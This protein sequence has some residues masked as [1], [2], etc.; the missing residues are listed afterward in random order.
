M[1]N[2]QQTTRRS[3]TTTFEVNSKRIADLEFGIAVAERNGDAITEALMNHPA[4]ATWNGLQALGIDH[5]LAAELLQRMEMPR[6]S[7]VYFDYLIPILPPEKRNHPAFVRIQEKLGFTP[8]WRLEIC[9]KSNLWPADKHIRC[10]PKNYE[11][12]LDQ[13]S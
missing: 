5:P 10:D 8:E 3:G 11:L 4:N 12:E 13:S 1:T 6:S 9:R 7:A 2:T